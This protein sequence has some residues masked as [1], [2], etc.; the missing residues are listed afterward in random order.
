MAIKI[1]DLE[2]SELPAELWFE[3]NYKAVWLLVRLRGQL[4]GYVKL[5]LENGHVGRDKIQQELVEQ[6]GW[7]LDA[8]LVGQLL[9]DGGVEAGDFEQFRAALHRQEEVNLPNH[10]PMVSV[11]I[12][13]RDRP[14]SLQRCLTSLSQQNYANF[15]VLVVDNA[16]KTSQTAEV[17]KN[18]P[19]DN[20]LARK[21]R[22]ILEPKPGL[23]WAR[24]RGIDEAQGEIIAYTDDDV[25]VD[26]GWLAALARNFA[27]PGIGCVTGLVVPLELE[28][29]AQ[30]LFEKYGGFGRGFVRKYYHYTSQTH[31]NYP[32]GAGIFGTGA[33]MAFRRAIFAK[34]GSFETA[35]G[36]GTATAGG[37]DHEIFFRVLKAGYTLVYE[38]AALI[39]H[40][41][42]RDMAGLALQLYNFGRAELAYITRVFLKYP[43]ER[44]RAVRL[45]IW[46]FILYGLRRFVRE[47]RHSTGFPR[48]LI[49][50]EMRG[51]LVGPLAYLRSR[52]HVRQIAGGKHQIKPL[53]TMWKEGEPSQASSF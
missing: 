32:M 1:F 3:P 43:D 25:A 30:E 22:Y 33:N 47:T 15:E 26:A 23:S 19:V 17:L 6:L 37:E 13:T 31:R 24:N 21:L 29:P 36:A 9:T 35:L 34:I 51:S 5:I 53:T 2:L 14:E 40:Q 38:P 8:H 12:C 27:E 10:L 18:W 50:A 16:P 20:A 45:V 7:R 44:R 4:L 41:H 52:R 42:R 11:V 49:I 48:R 39:R 46:W 28:T